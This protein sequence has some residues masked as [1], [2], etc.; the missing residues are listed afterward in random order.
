MSVVLLHP[1]GLDSTAWPMS[2]STRPGVHC[3]DLP[4]HG[5]RAGESVPTFIGDLVED[6]LAI[7]AVR[8]GGCTLVGVSTGGMLAMHAALSAPALI[9]SLV[10]A[11]SA[12]RFDP[13]LMRARADEA[14]N[15]GAAYQLPQ[16]LRRWF[17][18][19]AFDPPVKPCVDEAANRWQAMSGDSL[20]DT[21]L[22]LAQ[23]DVADRINEIP[24]PVTVVIGIDDDPLG[25][26][27]GQCL[28]DQ[29]PAARLVGIPGS[30]MA[31]FEQPDVFERVI[32]RHM[33]LI[34]RANN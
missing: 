24:L 14:R 25:V 30:H 16:T 29:I 32:T 23:H 20:A 17:T 6:V 22:L 2:L 21:W 33:G 10:I 5:T 11:C 34:A 3:Y 27:A 19:E 4:G 12:A 26:D 31:P 15:H 28:A 9:D 1:I 18:P 7:P 13:A 8:E